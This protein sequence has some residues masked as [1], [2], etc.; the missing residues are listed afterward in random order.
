[1]V[2]VVLGLKRAT[3]RVPGGAQLQ[4]RCESC[5]EDTTFYEKEL[6]STFRLYFL[7]VF[8]FNR[9][10]VMACG[11]CGACYVTDEVGGARLPSHTASLEKQLE[12]GGQA[13]GKFAADMG[14]SAATVGAEI[15]RGLRT[16]ASDVTRGLSDLAARAGSGSLP[17]LAK[18][19]VAT[20]AA[21]PQ[22]E[23]DPEPSADE[24]VGL[25]EL[26]VPDD[27][28]ERFRELERKAGIR[29]DR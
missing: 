29:R 10:R 22:R 20:V 26:D 9:D 15:S 23:R 17:D 27:L 4:R 16:T 25:R 11:A 6:K 18:R 8:D 12:R 5:Q 24:V 7:D 28:E 13:V 2:W 3:E 19:A 1:M 21:G 14:E